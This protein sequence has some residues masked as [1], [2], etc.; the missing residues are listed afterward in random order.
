MSLEDL[1]KE[2]YGQRPTHTH[3]SEPTPKNEE[4]VV[5]TSSRFDPW[6]TGK[7]QQASQNKV[8]IKNSNPAQKTG[9]VGRGIL[10]GG[11]VVLLVLMGFAGYYLYQYFTTKDIVLT[12]STPDQISVG[13]P[14]TATLSFENIS[15]KK[16]IAPKV[17]LALPEGVVFVDTPDKR[18][19]EADIHDIDPQETIRME[20]ALLVVGKSQQAYELNGGVSYGYEAT[21]L[22]SRFD[23]GVTA[24]VIAND[25]VFG[26][27]VTAPEKTINGAELDINT[28]YQNTSAHDLASTTITFT[29]PKGFV[30]TGSSV[31]LD[32]DNTAT[33]NTIPAHGEGT[34]VVSGYIVGDVY[35]YFTTQVDAHAQV[36]TIVVPLMSKTVSISILP[37]PLSVA[38]SRDRATTPDVV[39][40]GNKISYQVRIENT[41]D[42]P[43]ID[44]VAQVVLDNALFDATSLQGTGH[45]DDK[46]RTY[47]WTAAQVEALKEI[48]PHAS[49]SIP[50]SVMLKGASAQDVLQQKNLIVRAQVTS[51]TVPSSISAKETIG[52]SQIESKLGGAL[53]FSQKAY[54]KEPI[55]DIVNQG[56]LPPRVASPIQYTIHWKLSGMGNFNSSTVKATLSPGVSWTG[57][58]KVLGTDAVPTY[59]TRTQEIVWNI[60][61]LTAAAMASTTPEVVFQ[62]VFTP[63]SQNNGNTFEIISD[64]QMDSTEVISQKK[65]ESSVKGLT[66]RQLEDEKLPEGY[67]R[68]LPAQQ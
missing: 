41:G 5:N 17:S 62:V 48:A 6:D 38:I 53:G 31:P 58:I 52:I 35:S 57:K 39:Y 26:L 30:V 55:S 20:Y 68:V 59:N 4:V 25:A 10:L 36:G 2:L 46:T 15:T 60:P 56:S 29:F 67:Y 1:E 14:F 43:L 54:F 33:I 18:T 11:V 64:A 49:F 37:S 61:T 27:E 16:L 3:E 32:K 63:S 22:S 7:K 44:A 9:V 21:S 34:I 13:E 19:N 45:F 42:V 51:P 50:F 24:S 65:V 12:I 28:R 47:T 23:K 66:S 40:A 8:S